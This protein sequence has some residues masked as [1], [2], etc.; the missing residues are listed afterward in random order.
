MR[1]LRPAGVPEQHQA[2]GSG[3]C[4]RWS[5][6]GRKDVVV[7]AR[8]ARGVR[9]ALRCAALLGW[10]NSTLRRAEKQYDYTCGHG[11]PRYARRRVQNAAC[12]SAGAA[13]RRCRG[14][15]A[16]M[17]SDAQRQAAAQL[18]HAHSG[19][20]HVMCRGR[21]IES[22]AGDAAGCGRASRCAPATAARS[23][24]VRRVCEL[25]G[26]AH[27]VAEERR[28]VE[29]VGCARGR[30]RRPAGRR[31]SACTAACR[32]EASAAGVAPAASRRQYVAESAAARSR[33]FGSAGAQQRTQLWNAARKEGITVRRCG[34]WRTWSG[35]Q[36]WRAS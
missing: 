14:A 13:P 33:V 1:R 3:P 20:E 27:A 26:G 35:L 29:A 24:V 7:R 2:F 36:A 17:G 28:R 22:R 25:V 23:V 8:A 4:S 19:R 10:A 11:T 6:A 15:C 34:E 18:K 16:Q 12:A 30:Q 9:R 31:D 32:A 21:S 5:S